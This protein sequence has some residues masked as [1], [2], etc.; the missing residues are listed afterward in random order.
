MPHQR[1][2]GADPNQRTQSSHQTDLGAT[3]LSNVDALFRA[4]RNNEILHCLRDTD[5]AS[6]DSGTRSQLHVK[7]GA[8]LYDVGDLTGA[9]S[10]LR[11]GLEQARSA[12]VP[13]QFAAAF[14]L[15]NR[16][17]DVHSPEEVLPALSQLR[18]LAASLGNSEAL[19]A[20]HLA[21]ARREGMRGNFIDSRRHVE[22]ARR[23]TEREAT[24]ST[25]CSLDTVESSLEI[26]SGNLV[27][28]RVVGERGFQRAVSIGF[29]RYLAGCATN[30]SAIAIITGNIPAAR[31]YVEHVLGAAHDSNRIR[32][33]ALD[34]LLQIALFEGKRDGAQR[35]LDECASLVSTLKSPRRSWY[36]LSHQ[37]TR[38]QCSELSQDWPAVIALVDD[39]DH[40]LSHRH[41]QALRTVLMAAKARA[42]CQLGDWEQAADV[43]GKAERACPM[44]A[45][46]ALIILEASKGL[47]LTRKGEVVRG[48]THVERA[49]AACRTIGHRYCEWWIDQGRNLFAPS[50]RH[51]VPVRR[52]DID[53]AHAALLL[54]DVTAILGAGHSIDLLTHRTV[55]VLENAFPEGRVEIKSKSGREY[56]ADVSARCEH[57]A[58]GIFRIHL[59]GSDRSVSIQLRD[60]RSL[61][62]VSLV[63]SVADLVRAA[64]QRTAAAEDRR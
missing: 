8:A 62:E 60:V 14:A 47:C 32:F 41:L 3:M 12:P 64:V 61:D 55:S 39:V 10:T 34:N 26:V 9:I 53:P 52:R 51:I 56:R 22:L 63:K 40:E 25:L 46:E 21:V 48:T 28:A 11:A 42:L 57:G 15:F 7:L 19:G 27:R 54:S 31:Q 58:D 33:C 45:V 37:S 1:R 43:I 18:Q 50:A 6:F 20:L 13:L 24:V 16:E 49:L 36:E 2:A 30:L 17:A 29:S 44:G 5:F 38:C 59:R 35:I 23:L 4:G